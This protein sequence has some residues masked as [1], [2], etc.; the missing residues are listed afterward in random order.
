MIILCRFVIH[1]HS[2]EPTIKEN[3]TVFVSA[4]PF[5]LRKPKI[6]DI[7]A[8]KHPHDNKTFIKR[9][10]M[11]ENKKYF[12]QGDNKSDSIDSRKFG[13]IGK[14]LIIGKVLLLNC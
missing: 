2:M 10:I 6:N 4:L 12:V 7:V 5:L 8:I 14:E 13:M 9:I 1:G 11:I 3:Q